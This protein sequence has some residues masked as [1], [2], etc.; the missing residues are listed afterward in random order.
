[1]QTSVRRKVRG[2]LRR[3][4]DKKGE[5]IKLTRT[6]AQEVRRNIPRP[7][8]YEIF[9]IEIVRDYELKNQILALFILKQNTIS[10]KLKA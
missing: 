1:M 6:I 8:S 4:L 10:L 3:T 9:R 7:C 2:P 5:A